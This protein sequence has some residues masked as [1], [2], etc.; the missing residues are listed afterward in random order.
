MSITI[1]HGKQIKAGS[2]TRNKLDPLLEGQI[3]G[4]EGNV[5]N[6]IDTMSTDTERLAAI[7]DEANA[8]L[9]ADLVLDSRVQTLE[10][11]TSTNLSYDKYINRETPVGNIDGVNKVFTLE[12]TP[13]T[14][15]EMVFLNG[16]LLEPGSGNDYVLVDKEVTFTETPIVGDRVKVTY[17][18]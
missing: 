8:R 7:T 14:G 13:Y 17:F 9:T 2:I 6:I 12:Y 15:A 5:Q 4:I 11:Q 18:R 1:L 16:V 10:G 3:S